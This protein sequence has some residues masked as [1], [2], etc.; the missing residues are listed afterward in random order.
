MTDESPQ[1]LP[2]T[3]ESDNPE[4]TPIE[5]IHI[6]EELGSTDREN[7]SRTL[8]VAG[9][10]FGAIAIVIGIVSFATRPKP[11]ATGNIDDA[12]A[13]ALPGDNVLVTVR[14][15]FN[16]IGGKPLW[17]REIK[18][19]LTTTEG[20]QYTDDAASAADF[21]RYFHAYPDLRDH[22]IQPLKSETKAVPGEQIRGSVIVAF[23]VTMDA[24]NNRRS[25]SVIVVPHAS[26]VGPAG[27]DAIPVV[28]T[29][30]GR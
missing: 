6:A 13:V 18:A 15:N 29:Q 10:V 7:R 3:V 22:S 20:R 23:P 8:L 30:K 16:N 1:G 9:I 24:F 11:K 28:I 27:S 19:E 21:D 26:F 17:I 4:Q 25:L 14:V 12:Y 2:P 5:S